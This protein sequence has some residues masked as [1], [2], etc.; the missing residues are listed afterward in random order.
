MSN[1]MTKPP[2]GWL[3][4]FF[5]IPVYITRMGFAGWESLFG[6]E[7]ML[8]TTIGRKSG[9]KRY[10]MVDVLLYECETDT[11][12]IEAGF[13][14]K[15]DWYRNIQAHPIFE[16]QVRRRKFQATA[17]ELP[18]DK[19]GDIIIT[20]VRRRPAYAKSVMEMTGVTFTTEEELRRIASQW[21]LL[22]VHPQ[23]KTD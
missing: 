8:L 19:T 13:G 6:L 22:A 12:F 2:R 10:T 21:P 18:P 15:S 1:P 23:E 16:A 11:Y 5:K 9:K 3:K 20:F 4:F 7:W 17:E 14:K